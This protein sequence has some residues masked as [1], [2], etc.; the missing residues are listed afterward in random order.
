MKIFF[1]TNIIFF[2]FFFL[3]CFDLFV[4][5]QFRASDITPQCMTIL[6]TH[7]TLVRLIRAKSMS[8]P[9]W[10]AHLLVVMLWNLWSR[11][12]LN[13]IFLLIALISY[14]IGWR[15]WKN[16]W[17]EIQDFRLRLC[18]RLLLL[19]HRNDDRE[20]HNWGPANQKHRYC[21]GI[22]NLFGNFI[23]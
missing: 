17:R 23:S 10:L 2:I 13:V 11:F 18:H 20:K 4:Q 22:N 12:E 15:W 19:G 1:I 3:E 21:A 14:L 8:A 9:E 7:A 6:T 5:L 16:Y